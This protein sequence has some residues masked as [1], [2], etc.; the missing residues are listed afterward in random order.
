MPLFSAVLLGDEGPRQGRRRVS[1]QRA[2]KVRSSQGPSGARLTISIRRHRREQQQQQRLWRRRRHRH[3]LAL[4]P[5]PQRRPP[6]RKLDHRRTAEQPHRQ[7]DTGNADTGVG[8]YSTTCQP[9][10]AFYFVWL[11]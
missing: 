4:H 7:G 11:G 8:F 1:M 2:R 5:R 6:H 9:Y 3:G 10:E